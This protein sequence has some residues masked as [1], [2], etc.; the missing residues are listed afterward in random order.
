MPETSFEILTSLEGVSQASYF[1]KR[2]WVAVAPGALKDEE[3]AAYLSNAHRMVA[4]G[5]TR[6]ARA[7]LGLE[8]YLSAGTA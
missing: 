2:R 8:D 5:L 1:A 7:E 6:K 3:I 4:T